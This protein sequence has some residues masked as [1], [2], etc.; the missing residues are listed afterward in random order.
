MLML[1][2]IFGICVVAAIVGYCVGGD[3]ENLASVLGIILGLVSVVVAICLGACLYNSDNV[4]PSKIAYL[5]ENNIDIEAKL[6]AA[7]E[8]YKA[9]E[10]GTYGTFKPNTDSDITIACTQS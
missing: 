10:A 3:C 7:I 8:A 5:E 9:Y 1:I 2:L 6:S 4:R